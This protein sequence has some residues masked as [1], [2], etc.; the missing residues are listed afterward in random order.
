[1]RLGLY[2]HSNI[3]GGSWSIYHITVTQGIP[4]QWE[5]DMMKKLIPKIQHM[6]NTS[7]CK[8]LQGKVRWDDTDA[9]I[10]L[11]VPTGTSTGRHKLVFEDFCGWVRLFALETPSSPRQPADMSTL[12]LAKFGTT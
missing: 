5:T 1:M 11:V 4:T 9:V 6:L 2:Y 12:G 10:E 7:E 3:C 8:P